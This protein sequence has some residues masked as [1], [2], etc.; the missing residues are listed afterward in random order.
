MLFRSFVFE[1]RKANGTGCG[2]RLAIAQREKP[3]RLIGFISIN[4][5]EGQAT[6]GYW[7]GKPHWGKGLATEAAH[8][9]IDAVFSYTVI[10]DLHVSA[11]VANP[12]SR[13]V[14]EKC[15]FQFAGSDMQLAPARGGRVAVDRFRL[16]RSTWAS[17][18]G[19]RE[20]RIEI[21]QRS[22]PIAEPV[23]EACT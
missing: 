11:H 8:G 14:I 5:R 10:E 16:P 4:D 7:V 1:S 22:L 19:W 15:G 13:R 2:L 17:L 18:K 20:P 3:D 9:L 6:L 12:A 23:M 21:D